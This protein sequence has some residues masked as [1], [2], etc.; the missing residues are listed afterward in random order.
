MNTLHVVSQND[1]VR[2]RLRIIYHRSGA[3]IP[4]VSS[5]HNDCYNAAMRKPVL[6]TLLACQL[7]LLA[8][9]APASAQE[10][11]PDSQEHPTTEDVVH[12]AG[13]FV[14]GGQSFTVVFRSKRIVGAAVPDPEFQT[15]LAE[16]EIRDSAGRAHYHA[17]F[18]HEISGDEFTESL[19]AA[20]ELLQGRERSGLL[21]TYGIIPS[22]PLGG[23]SWQV[24]GLFDN[25]L[26]AFSAPI[27]AEGDLVN[28]PE[29]PP[30]SKR[31]RT[32]PSPG[33]AGEVMN[34]R[35]W[36][37]NFFVIY[38]VRVDF[39]Q[40]KLRPAFQC[41]RLTAQ[42]QQPW[43][44]YRIEAERRVP[45]VEMTFVRLHDEASEQMGTPRHVV[46]KKESSVEFI[47][48][49]GNVDWV[50]DENGIGLTPGDDFWLKVR[51]DAS[52]GWIHTQE[53]FDAIGLPQAG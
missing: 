36:T 32:A 43:C 6:T 39:V 7:L 19:S 29:G 34:F 21:I 24:F 13:P 41:S 40:A 37:G 3:A 16:L 49:E 51:I 12:E 28:A 44:Q 25:K 53:D 50:E 22:T 15:T 23:Q 48:A 30:E 14:L 47:A 38:P 33:L 31:V 10:P 5:K 20:V 4:I 11:S 42:G 26:V 18:P 27:F 35:V 52:E 1:A 17:A 2:Q 46:I 9:A 8:S 45:R